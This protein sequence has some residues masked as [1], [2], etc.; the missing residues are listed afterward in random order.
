MDGM[1]HVVKPQDVIV[2]MEIATT[3]FHLEGRVVDT[4]YVSQSD[5]DIGETHVIVNVNAKRDGAGPSAMN[6]TVVLTRAD[7]KMAGF[8]YLILLDLRLGGR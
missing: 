7:A 8:V 4:E 2:M 6:L 3:S 1:I 5:L